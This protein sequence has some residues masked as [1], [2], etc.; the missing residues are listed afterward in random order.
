MN[1]CKV[2]LTRGKNK[3]K[4]CGRK[5]NADFC[6]AHQKSA[7]EESGCEFILTR[8]NRKG[9][10]CNK[11]IK[12]GNFCY[13][14]S[15]EVEYVQCSVIIERGVRKGKICGRRCKSPDTICSTHKII[16]KN[17]NV[18]IEPVVEKESPVVI[19]PDVATV[20]EESSVVVEPVVATVVEESSV[21]VEPV[22]AT[23]VEESSVVVEPVVATVVEESSVVVEPDVATV[24]EESSVVVE[25]DVANVVE[26]PSVIEESVICEH[27]F[28]RG[29]KKGQQCLK[30]NCVLHKP[31]RKTLPISNDCK[32]QQVILLDYITKQEPENTGSVIVFQKTGEIELDLN[33]ECK[34]NSDIKKKN[35]INDKISVCYEKGRFKMNNRTGKYLLNDILQVFY[36]IYNTCAEAKH[37]VRITEITLH[38]NQRLTD[39]ARYYPVN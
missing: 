21:V 35:K 19:E 38:S 36:Y 25:P 6:R 13:S 23:V 1:T 17:K 27:I 29:A 11:K 20:V 15:P 4:E 24:L 9:E 10:K 34:L 12:N 7:A 28:T 39:N 31:K 37:P 22:V 33:F 30:K 2:V 16:K 18:V 26:N 5:T 14:H 8:G 32:D 3:G